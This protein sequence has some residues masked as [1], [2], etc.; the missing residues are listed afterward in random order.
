MLLKMNICSSK[1]YKTEKTNFF[2]ILSGFQ[3]IVVLIFGN[4]SEILLPN[5]ETSL[6]I[7]F[8]VQPDAFNL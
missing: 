6:L 8:V 7:Q 4:Y 5:F 2:N 3:V 1:E